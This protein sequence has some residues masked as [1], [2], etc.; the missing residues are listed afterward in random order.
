MKSKRPQL[1]SGKEKREDPETAIRTWASAAT[2][3]CQCCL[4]AV[5]CIFVNLAYMYWMETCTCFCWFWTRKWKLSEI[6]LRYHTLAK[7]YYFPNYIPGLYKRSSTDE[8]KILVF[9]L[10]KEKGKWFDIT[11]LLLPVE[12]W[13]ECFTLE[14]PTQLNFTTHSTSSFFLYFTIVLFSFLLKQMHQHNTAS[15]L[16]YTSLNMCTYF[17]FP[18][19]VNVLFTHIHICR[20]IF[21]RTYFIGLCW[22][23][24]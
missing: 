24:I 15:F 17:R 3:L 21:V 20:M 18:L 22:E 8:V 23:Y 9:C 10:Y 2:M 19:L 12:N 13:D 1:N 5:F 16:F 4:W 14:L 6:S 7:I 11:H